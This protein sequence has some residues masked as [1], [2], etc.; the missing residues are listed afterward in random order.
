MAGGFS[1]M[2]AWVDADLEGRAWLQSFRKVPPSTATIAGQWYDY[3]GASGNPPPN[4]YATTPYESAL[5]DPKL[6]IYVPDCGPDSVQYLHRLTL[7]S[8]AASATSTTNQNQSI[9]LLDYLLYYP[10]I[11]M[12]AV[13]EEQPMVNSVACPRYDDG[14]YLMIVAQAPTVGGGRFAINYTN[15]D[16]VPGRVSAG[17]FCAS[18][19]PAGALMSAVGAAGAA[20]PFCPLQEGDYRIKSLESLTVEVANGGLACAVIVRP[21]EA[22]YI[23]EECRRTTTGTVESF[24]AAVEIERMRQKFGACEIK[25]GAFLNCIGLGA[26]GSLA[27]SQLLGIV[28]TLWSN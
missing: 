20:L 1:G 3:S 27:S 12:E 4:Y 22:S 8:G 23:G 9:R 16:G 13:G 2:R 11:D 21:I 18:A 26:A 17:I 5:L 14:G 15:Q 25:R 28:E 6:G 19:Q 24:G 10:F 7:M